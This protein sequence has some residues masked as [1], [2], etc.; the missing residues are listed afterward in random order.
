MS[1]TAIILHRAASRRLSAFSSAFIDDNAFARGLIRKR[2]GYPPFGFECSLAARNHIGR[3]QRVG[4]SCLIG[5][6]ERAPLRGRVVIENDEKVYIAVRACFAA[7]GGAE[8]DDPP[9]I[10]IHDDRPQQFLWY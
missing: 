10:E 4:L 5:R 1:S 2:A 8:Q 7:S 9:R 3:I 6:P